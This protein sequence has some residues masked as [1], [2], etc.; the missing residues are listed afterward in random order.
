MSEPASS[1]DIPAFASSSYVSLGFVGGGRAQPGDQLDRHRQ[2]GPDLPRGAALF[3]Q[4]SYR[5]ILGGYRTGLVEEEAQKGRRGGGTGRYLASCFASPTLRRGSPCSEAEICRRSWS[6]ERS[7]S[8]LWAAQNTVLVSRRERAT[9]LSQAWGD[10]PDGPGSGL[11]TSAN[12]SPLNSELRPR[13][14]AEAG[15]GVERR[16]LRSGGIREATGRRCS[17]SGGLQKL[18]KGDHDLWDWLD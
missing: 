5:A 17:L 9:P 3:G 4:Q 14:C 13:G 11:R 12:S 6:K 15:D 1:L 18:A 10:P 16:D 2:F 8:K 7:D